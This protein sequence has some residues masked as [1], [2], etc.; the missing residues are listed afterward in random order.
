VKK[1]VNSY[2]ILALYVDDML[3]ADANVAEIDRLKKLYHT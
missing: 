2:I 3:I 1:Y